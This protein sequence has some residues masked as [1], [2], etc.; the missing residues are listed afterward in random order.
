MTEV[1]KNAGAL[2]L[3]AAIVV[4]L[5]S[6]VAAI[7]LSQA[8]SALLAGDVEQLSA[9]FEQ[10]QSA[11]DDG[12][13]D[14][15]AYMDPYYAF[16]TTEPSMQ[17]TVEAWLNAS[18]EGV[19]ARSAHA[20]M[21]VHRAN[22]LNGPQAPGNAPSAARKNVEIVA[23]TAKH[24]LLEILETRPDHLPSAYALDL[25][26]ALTSDDQLRGTALALLAENDNPLPALLAE[27]R[28][29]EFETW[30][31][32]ASALCRDRTKQIQDFTS[33]QCMTF[34]KL[35]RGRYTSRGIGG[36]H[37]TLPDSPDAQMNNLEGAKIMHRDPATAFKIAVVSRDV[38]PSQVMN[39]AYRLG[40]NRIL[41]EIVLPRLEFDPLNPQ[42]LTVLGQIQFQK[43]RPS[44][45]FQTIESA[46]ELGEHDPSVRLARIKFMTANQEMRW[47]TTEELLDAFSATD[48][49]MKLVTRF[50]NRVMSP[51]DM[52]LYREDG[53]VNPDFECVQLLF[54][55]RF[56][57]WCA[58]GIGASGRSPSNKCSG[59][60][61]V[62]MD[63]LANRVRKSGV[64]GPA[65]DW[66]QRTAWLIEHRQ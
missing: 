59:N 39:L 51:P 32:D 48:G 7:E 65:E 53:S 15:D 14:R 25:L 1:K 21:Q 23:Q 49:S 5:S 29:A 26:G 20:I 27:L 3:L 12:Q 22:L 40:P 47:K 56:L 36:S 66:R 45:A 28:Y 16:A 34:A 60:S 11:F 50:A 46:L 8:R 63:A 10:H 62:Q 30:P 2:G 43:G 52:L 54:V 13:I 38:T 37:S 61:A 33:G 24:D 55:E 18:P 35:E 64:C 44:L 31:S 9:G 4:L 6:P 17:A 42:W 19:Q 41:N 58:Q 57:D